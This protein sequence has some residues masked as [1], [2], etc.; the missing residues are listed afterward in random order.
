MGSPTKN[1]NSVIKCL[2]Q[3][4][5]DINKNVL[6][7]ILGP[8]TSEDDLKCLLEHEKIREQCGERQLRLL[9]LW[10]DADTA[11][12]LRS[13]ERLLEYVNL[14]TMS[15]ERLESIMNRNSAIF[16]CEPSRYVLRI[17]SLPSQDNL[18]LRPTNLLCR[19]ST[20][21]QKLRMSREN[22]F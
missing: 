6:S 2:S 15:C 3:L 10:I 13:L 11:T 17:T 7:N 8:D 16:T 1:A 19:T 22:N 4:G 9:A 12:R 18:F 5:D 14:E 20:Q 21:T